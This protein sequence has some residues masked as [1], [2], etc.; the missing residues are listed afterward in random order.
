MVEPAQTEKALAQLEGRRRLFPPTYH[1]I[2]IRPHLAL[3]FSCRVSSFAINGKDRSQAAVAARSHKNE[4][5]TQD[6]SGTG[7][8]R[9]WWWNEGRVSGQ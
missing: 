6:E 3:D 1:V 5:C 4:V 7:L 2:E 9:W 8:T